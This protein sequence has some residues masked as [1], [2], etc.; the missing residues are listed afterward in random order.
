MN[1]SKEIYLLDEIK[2]LRGKIIKL[3]KEIKG[4]WR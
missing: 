4:L 3:Q 2:L 1:E